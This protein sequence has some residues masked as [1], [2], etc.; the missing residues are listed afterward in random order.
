[1][2]RE[3]FR[4]KPVSGLLMPIPNRR[5]QLLR[6]RS[7]FPH[8]PNLPRMGCEQKQTERT[9]KRSALL[10]ANLQQCRPSLRL[11]CFLRYLLLNLNSGNW[12]PRNTRN[13]QTGKGFGRN[14][15]PFIRPGE[16]IC[17]AKCSV[18]RLF[19][20]GQRISRFIPTA[21]ARLNLVHGP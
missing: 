8:S 2:G 11:L 21:E 15:P 10:N 14:R 19:S 4:M 3:Q 13:T 6:R 20:R 17:E 12:K 7:Q 1:M 16:G 5:W 18:H 9:E